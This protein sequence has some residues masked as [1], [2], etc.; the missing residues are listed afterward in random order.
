MN[1]ITLGDINEYP[2]IPDNHYWLYC[3]E[4]KPSANPFDLFLQKFGRSAREAIVGKKVKTDI[5][6]PNSVKVTGATTPGHI[7]LR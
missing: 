6:I 1:L 5:N 2:Q 3:I 4:A 7:G